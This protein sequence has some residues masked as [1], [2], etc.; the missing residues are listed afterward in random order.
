[1]GERECVQK[2]DPF[3]P[4]VNWL[5]VVSHAVLNWAAGF[6]RTLQPLFPIARLAKTPGDGVFNTVLWKNLSVLPHLQSVQYWSQASTLLCQFCPG[7]HWACIMPLTGL[8]FP[9]K[10][11]TGFP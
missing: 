9:P 1:M 11:A 2:P 5:S 6:T 8:L 3:L 4:D 7:R 10:F